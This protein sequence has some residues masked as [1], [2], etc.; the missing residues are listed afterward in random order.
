[1]TLTDKERLA[2]ECFAGNT[3][4]R[5]TKADMLRPLG[6]G[7]T[8]IRGRSTIVRLL[9]KGVIEHA[10]YVLGARKERVICAYRLKA[11]T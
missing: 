1:M 6:L 9:R 11:S 4:R 7:A 2:L 8:S 3:D 10:G 5:C